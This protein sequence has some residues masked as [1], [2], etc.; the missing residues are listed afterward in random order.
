M[1]NRMKN[2]GTKQV[3]VHLYNSCAY[4]THNT[5]YSIFSQNTHHNKLDSTHIDGIIKCVRTKYTCIA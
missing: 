2:G 3:N 4:S 5:K 1:D